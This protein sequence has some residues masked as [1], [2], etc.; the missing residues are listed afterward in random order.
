VSESRPRLSIIVP[1]RDRP[2]KLDRCL[3][4]VTAAMG[5]DDELLV[6]DSASEQ[7]RAVADVAG[8]HGATLVRCDLP[9]VCRARNAG[10]REAR[11]ALLGYTDDDVVVDTRWADAI[12]AT[13]GS[14]DGVDFLTG[15]TGW[16]EGTLPP[17][18]PVAVKDL[19]DPEVLDRDARGDLGHSANMAIRAEALDAVGGWD[20]ALG[21]GGRFRAAPEVDLFDRLLL[22]GRIGRYE[23]T[24]RAWHEQWRGERELIG[25]DWRYGLG[26]GA[27]LSK[28]V[29]TDRPRALRI[30]R[31]AMW[32]W[33]LRAAA[34][35]LRHGYER[36][37]L[38]A[39]ARVAGTVVGFGRGL[40][41]P[42]QRG[43]FK[44]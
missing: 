19:P 7:R 17:A 40:T 12:V 38:M 31:E 9:G 36:G 43:C 15:R 11:A 32:D 35:E 27:R 20:E 14:H 8:R 6:V 13:F 1:T 4:S 23:P 37:A 5:P 18:R 41:V 39:L 33:G 34:D 10:A 28:L 29:R 2:E 3:A 26:N 24:M 44:T 42:I 25:L 22:V 16:P 21:A 30:G